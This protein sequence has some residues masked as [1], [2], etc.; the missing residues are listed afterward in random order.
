MKMLQKL[1]PQQI[2][3]I[4]LL[5]LNT[6]DMEQRVDEELLENPALEKKDEDEDEESPEKEIGEDDIQGIEEDLKL[7]GNEEEVIPKSE[8]EE[9]LEVAEEYEED[10]LFDI[11][12]YTSDDGDEDGY[13]LY[14]DGNGQEERKE[15]PIASNTTFHD[16]LIEQFEAIANDELDEKM[17]TQII[18]SLDEDG[19]LRRNLDAI[20]NDLAFSASVDC[21]VE[22]LEHTLHKIQSLDP[23]GI[24]AR[25]LQECLL[26]QLKRLEKTRVGVLLALRIISDERYME[27][28]IKKHYEK[29]TKGLKIEEEQLKEAIAIIVKLNPKPGENDSNSKSQYVIPDFTLVNEEGRLEVSLNSRNVPPLR[30]SRSYIDTLKNYD[31][32]PTSNKQVKDTVMFIKQKLDSA[33]WFIDSIKQRHNTLLM[34]MNAIAR[35]QYQ[36]FQDGDERTL[37]PMILKDIADKIGMDISTVSRVANSKYVD[38]E[39]GIFALKFFFSEGVT[40]DEGEEVSNKEIKRILQDCIGVED[41]KNPFADERLMK[42]LK[43]KG[44]PIARRTVAKYREQIGIP[45]AR[46]RREL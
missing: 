34:T 32:N 19:Y 27:A 42:I 1:S 26:L 20:A 33:K 22:Q 23:P 8:D 45:V 9:P 38:T 21:T 10:A 11:A 41:K 16:S 25:T 35:H 13:H 28:F 46:L 44:Y 4:K 14:E 24:A 12:D 37:K 29:L 15:M 5:Q 36:F 3:F 30:V 18:G 17:G 7:S 31:K 6:L 2:Q 40:N 43:E 39:F